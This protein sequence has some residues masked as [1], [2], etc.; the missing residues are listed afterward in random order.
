LTARIAVFPTIAAR[1]PPFETAPPIADTL[2]EMRRQLTAIL[3]LAA[4]TVQAALGALPGAVALCL[5][6]GHEHA[7]TEIVGECELACD[8]ESKLPAPVPAEDHDCDCTDVELSLVELVTTPRDEFSPSEMPLAPVSICLIELSGDAG[9][10]P[11]RARCADPGAR[12]RI[13]IIKSTRLLI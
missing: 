6:G 2:S 13:D 12:T 3:L 11:P 7:P 8:H 1:G 4:I 5:G 10:T 9:R